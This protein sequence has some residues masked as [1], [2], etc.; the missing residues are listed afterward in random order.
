MSDLERLTTW[1]REQVGTRESGENNVIYNTHY[2]GR[3]VQGPEYPWC[4]SFL[5]DAFR[6]CGLS[7]LFLGGGKSAYCPFVVQWAREHGRWVTG[8]YRHGDLLMY[9]WNSDGLADH[10]GFCLGMS[11]GRLDSI[12]GNIND[13]VCVTH[14]LPVS[15][16]GAYRPAYENAEKPVQEPPAQAKLYDV[17]LPM[18]QRGDTGSAVLSVQLLLIHKWAIS[19][20]IDGADGEYGPATES[21]VRAFQRHKGLEEDGVAGPLT[22]AALIGQ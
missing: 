10:V 1:L 11:A 6:E 22:L 5:W 14:R 18:L 3:E 7:G 9:D 21:A 16:M 20:G 17:K 4:L 2:Y 12:E 13:E 19:C 15:V 8:D